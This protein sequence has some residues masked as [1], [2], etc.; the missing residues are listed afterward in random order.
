MFRKRRKKEVEE[1]IPNILAALGRAAF[2]DKKDFKQIKKLKLP[3]DIRD[4]HNFLCF[5]GLV[6]LG[7][8][9]VFEYIKN[10]VNRIVSNTENASD[11]IQQIS[12]DT[13]D[14]FIQQLHDEGIPQD[15]LDEAL[16]SFIIPTVKDIEKYYGNMQGSY[17][18]NKWGVISVVLWRVLGEQ[19]AL[20][21]IT[22]TGYF[23]YMKIRMHFDA[24][25]IESIK[26]LISPTGDMANKIDD[27]LRESIYL[28]NGNISEHEQKIATRL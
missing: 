19:D 17:P 13:Q 4:A 20:E 12:K 25:F 6:A 16:K 5:T 18:G 27:M 23:E 2:T 26:S 24:L 3:F 8:F 22:K 1:N 15:I 10:A 28:T 21:T 14:A 7:M 9:L 11:I